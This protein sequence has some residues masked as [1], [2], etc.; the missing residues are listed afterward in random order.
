VVVL[1]SGKCLYCGERIPGA[2]HVEETRP[3][4]PP[5]LMF[6]LQPRPARVST[7]R[8]WIGR[9]IAMGVSSLLVGLM[10]GPCMKS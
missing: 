6:S 2:L 10:M 4:L 7:R 5:E 9:A 1:K 3:G 8:K